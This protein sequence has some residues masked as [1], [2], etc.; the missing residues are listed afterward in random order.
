LALLKARYPDRTVVDR[1][2]ALLRA[3]QRP[4]GDWQQE[5]ICGK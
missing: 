1:G 2:I 3:R 4:D 5:S